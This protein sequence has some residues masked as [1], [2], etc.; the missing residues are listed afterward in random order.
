MSLVY[1]KYG[2][3]KGEVTAE[4][5]ED[6]IMLDS[7]DWRATRN[8]TNPMGQVATREKGDVYITE[9]ACSRTN[10]KASASLLKACLTGTAKDAVIHYTKSN[11]S[12]GFEMYMELKL[13]D[14]LVGS[15]SSHSSGEKPDEKMTLNFSKIEEKYIPYDAQHK[16]Q[17]PI[18][19]GYDLKLTKALG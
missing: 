5:H 2:D 16:A 15:Y 17:G 11:E 10:D 6:W 19:T 7:V 13:T 18:I 4:G 8:L 1:L 3:I 9:I 12:G 14:C